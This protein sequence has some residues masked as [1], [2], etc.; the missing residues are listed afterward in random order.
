MAEALVAAASGK[1][2]W[3][4]LHYTHMTGHRNRRSECGARRKRTAMQLQRSWGARIAGIERK[5]PRWSNGLGGM[6]A[7]DEH[8]AQRNSVLEATPRLYIARAETTSALI[9][10]TDLRGRTVSTSHLLRGGFGK[11]S[12]RLDVNSPIGKRIVQAI[13]G[14]ARDVLLQESFA[15]G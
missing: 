2:R 3:H 5:D 13:H 1:D 14:E 6:C 8:S 15:L 11:R 9:D 7:M 12:A 10:S 4:L